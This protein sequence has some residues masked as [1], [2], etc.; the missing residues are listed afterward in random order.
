VQE[1]DDRLIDFVQHLFELHVYWLGFVNHDVESAEA[2]RR[3]HRWM[4]AVLPPPKEQ[5]ETIRVTG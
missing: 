5:D 3:C 1:V 4:D 2:H